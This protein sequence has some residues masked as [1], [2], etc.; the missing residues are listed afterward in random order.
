MNDSPLLF[1]NIILR[2]TTQLALF[3]YLEVFTPNLTKE[4][5]DILDIIFYIRSVGY[6]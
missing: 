4:N 2:P 6:N 1:L 3:F 5:M